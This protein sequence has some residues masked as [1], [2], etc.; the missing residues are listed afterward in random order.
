[1]ARILHFN[2]SPSVPIFSSTFFVIIPP[3][4]YRLPIRS[5]SSPEP[6]RFS[7]APHLLSR[8]KAPPTWKY[9]TPITRQPPPLF[10]APRPACLVQLPFPVTVRS[11]LLRP[12]PA[13]RSLSDPGGFARCESLRASVFLTFPTQGSPSNPGIVRSLVSCRV[14]FCTRA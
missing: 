4:S 3:L 1:M 10:P 2:S 14:A 13:P 6:S 11:P 9:T 12:W 5:R 8:C 7:P